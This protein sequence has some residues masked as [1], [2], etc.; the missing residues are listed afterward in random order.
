MIEITTSDG[1]LIFSMG[2]SAAAWQARKTVARTVIVGHRLQGANSTVQAP[3]IV[4][5]KVQQVSHFGLI[6]SD[7]L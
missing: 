3:A 2:L 1:N 4:I 5:L 6:Q 7:L